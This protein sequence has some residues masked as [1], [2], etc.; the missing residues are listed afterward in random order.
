MRRMKRWVGMG[1]CAWWLAGCGEAPTPNVP[2][3]YAE[4][5]GRE[6]RVVAEEEFAKALALLTRHDRDND[7][8][9]ARCE[10]TA[11]AFSLAA[12]LFGKSP[13]GVGKQHNA[14][15]NAAVALVR[16][17]LHAAAEK[18][19]AALVRADP[20]HHR[21]A[22]Q[23][24]LVRH[25]RGGSVDTAIAA[26][27]SAISAGK[28]QDAEALVSLAALQLQRHG[29][30]PSGKREDLAQARLNLQ[31]ALAIDDAFM[32]ALNQ[33]AILQL[34]EAGA[35]ERH[36]QIAASSAAVERSA[37]APLELAALIC[38]QAIQK[39]PTYAPI[40]NTAGLVSVR[41]GDLSA[42][43][44]SFATARTLDPSFFEAHM[45]YAAVNLR[46]R[47]FAP[48]E[49]AY[50]KALALRPK[51][52]DAVLGLSLALRGR[53]GGGQGEALLARAAKL[54]ERA[55]NIDPSRPE[56]YFN[57]AILIQEF[58]ARGLPPERA[59]AVLLEAKE[60][61]AVFLERAKGEG[62]LTDARA[63]AEARM[64]DIDEMLA[65]MQ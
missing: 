32:P 39:A 20:S 5:V 54:L 16:C 63:R 29:E 21:A 53:S 45:N 28:F 36:L 38:S 55:K 65:F 19:L 26:L 14:R 35:R 42:A 49:E 8:T 30:R 59:K 64:R 12:E 48:A 18:E 11:K 1:L 4:L 33:L 10:T 37:Q 7:W 31:R 17:G 2:P 23:L 9:S 47:G 61:F 41:L 62:A 13:G 22:A 44:K 15:Y 58:N 52:Y 3:A 6:A 46:F 24:A 51:S 34:E 60:L 57:Q 25:H 40:H 27:E 56:A 50:E 43:A